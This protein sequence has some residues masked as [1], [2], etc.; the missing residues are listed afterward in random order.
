VTLGG[1][2]APPR[3]ALERELR[4]VLDRLRSLPLERLGDPAPPW[5]SRT[6]AAAATGQ[7]LADLAQDLEEGPGA[8]RRALPALA[9]AAAPDLVAVPAHDLLLALR[10][11]APDAGAAAAAGHEA[12]VRL[13]R[14]L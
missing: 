1:G 5:G 7:V 3:E 4:R 10:A 12:L 13:R 14:A 11:H 9:P 6:E 2:A 8:A